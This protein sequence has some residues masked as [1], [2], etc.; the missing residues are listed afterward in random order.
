MQF[1]FLP[2]DGS[3]RRLNFVTVNVRHLAEIAHAERSERTEREI[4]APPGGVGGRTVG[5]SAQQ[6]IAVIATAA[7]IV[8]RIG[9]SNCASSV[10]RRRLRPLIS[11]SHRLY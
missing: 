5:E 8:W 6:R 3:S 1:T 2:I 9:V 4:C 10:S 7:P 11:F